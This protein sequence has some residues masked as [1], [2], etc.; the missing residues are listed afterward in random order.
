MHRVTV[1]A[2][3]SPSRCHPSTELLDS[4]FESLIFVGA[5]VCRKII[6]LDGYII[7][8]TD[9][10]ETKRGRVSNFLA[11]AYERY[12][13]VIIA[14]ANEHLHVVRSERHRGFA[15]CVLLGLGISTSPVTLLLTLSYTSCCR[16]RVL[17]YCSAR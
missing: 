12:C 16:D 3:S 7:S 9:R 13:D 14:R 2:V 8:P 6:V 1:V 11:S 10:V 17:S 4:V 5:H 15:M